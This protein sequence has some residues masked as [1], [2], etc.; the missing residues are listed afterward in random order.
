MDK[1]LSKIAR[2]HSMESF[3]TVD[4]PGIRFVLFL[5]GCHLKCKY[6]QNRDTWDVNSGTIYDIK[7]VVKRIE[8]YTAYMQ[9]NG[10]I[11]VSGGEPLCKENINEVHKFIKDVKAIKPNF[12]IWCY[13]GYTMD[14]LL[15]RNDED[16]NKCLNDI[17]V[18][19]DGTYKDELHNPT[20][21]W[22]G[23]S[24]QRVIDVQKSLKN[25]EIVLLK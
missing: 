21:K 8:R 9:K 6:C 17:D 11:T 7:D 22:K 3:G 20:L 25:N 10:G 4:G 23:S 24:N 1:D 13:S 16:T 19:V 5:Q 18:L 15:A 2:I 12:D 14:E